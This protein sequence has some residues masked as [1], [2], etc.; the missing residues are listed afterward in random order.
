MTSIVEYTVV[1]PCLVTRIRE[2]RAQSLTIPEGGVIGFCGIRLYAKNHEGNWETLL[3]SR[4]ALIYWLN[5]HDVKKKNTNP[6]NAF[7]RFKKVAEALRKEKSS[8]EQ[9]VSGG[10]G[11]VPV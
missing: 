4:K 8:K 7:E 11:G 6:P 1:N 2:G 3:T 5:N 9:A 10:E